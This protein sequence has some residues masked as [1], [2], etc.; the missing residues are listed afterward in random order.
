MSPWSCSIRALSVCRDGDLARVMG[1]GIRTP[2][3]GTAKLL[4][5]AAAC[6][7]VRFLP[8]EGERQRK[9]NSESRIAEVFAPLATGAISI[10]FS[11]STISNEQSADR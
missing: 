6:S 2:N 10:E 5:I 11:S 7:V 1:K 9:A 3:T 8:M 4:M